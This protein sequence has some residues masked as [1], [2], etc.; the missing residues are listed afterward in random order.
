METQLDQIATL[1]Q[2]DKAPAY[3]SI[4]SNVFSR[5]DQSTVPADIH[6]LVENVLQ[7]S[8][9]PVIGRQVLAELV[10]NLEEGV[11]KN[12]EL[13]RRTV[14]GALALIQPRLISYEEQVSGYFE[15]CTLISRSIG[16]F[17][18]LPIGRSSRK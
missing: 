11:V 2:K 8:V 18:A 14:E 7:D 12:P 1:S 10:K 16:E 15:K 6:I 4:L 9:G 3:L 5:A 17:F 13:R